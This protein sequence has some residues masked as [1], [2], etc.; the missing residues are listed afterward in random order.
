MEEREGGRASASGAHLDPKPDRAVLKFYI[1]PSWDFRQHQIAV[2]APDWWNDM[3]QE[4]KN[5]FLDEE[6]ERWL[7]NGETIE[8]GAMELDREAEGKSSSHNWNAFNPADDEI[9]EWF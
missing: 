1:Q 5:K 3:T 8:Y 4:E 9:E 6:A 7:L 2:W